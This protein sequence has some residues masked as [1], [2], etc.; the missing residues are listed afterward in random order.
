M[1]K[2]IL[3]IFF[4]LA[5]MIPAT[6]AQDTF[7]I[8]AVDSVTGEIGSAGASCVGSSSSYPHG[9]QILSD[10]IPGVGAIH[11]QASWV[12]ANQQ[13]AHDWM[14]QGLSPQQIIDSLVAHDAGM[15]PT[16]RQY[17]IVDYNGGQP[18]SASYTGVNCLNYKN[19]TAGFSYSIQGNILLG[20]EILDSMQARFLG[21]QGTLAERLMA[22]LQGAKVIGAD[23]RCAV[24]NTSSQS[25]FI[26]VATLT[27]QPDSLYLDLWMAYP[28]NYSG[29]FPVDPI[30]SLQGMFDDWQAAMAVNPLVMNPN[31]VKVFPCDDGSVTFDFT[32]CR[33]YLG[34][35]LRIYDVA[36][37]VVA[38]RQVDARTMQVSLAG[39]S[40][41]MMIYQLVDRAAAVVARGKFFPFS[42]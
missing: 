27:N 33:N 17:G 9:A 24:R 10:V 36:G 26:R 6:L 3:L 20:Q 34:M 18:R 21:T 12:A 37:R 23:T 41:G 7:S 28:Q 40:R 4:L 32:G 8:V 22:A 42:R 15:N 16:I 25:A 13:H 31:V 35:H 30:D 19:D 1:K 39:N 11:T 5:M 2:H 29:Q 38:A 14:M